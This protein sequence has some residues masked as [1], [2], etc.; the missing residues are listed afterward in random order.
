MHPVYFSPHPLLKGLISTFG[1]LYADF[2]QVNISPNYTFPWSAQ[3]RLNF[4]LQGA[5]I[6]VKKDSASH[7]NRLPLVSL[8]GPQL[9]SSALQFDRNGATA[10]VC[11]HPGG[12]YR[13]TGIPVHELVNQELDAGFVFGPQVWEIGRQLQDAKDTSAVQEIVEGFLLQ[14]LYEKNR[15]LRPFDH[16][17]L[18]LIKSNGNLS[19]STAAAA[20][21]M[22]TRHFERLCNE[23]LGISPKL[24]AR[25]V[26]FSRAHALIETQGGKSLSSIAYECGYYDQ[27]HLIHDCRKFS[28]ATPRMI[29]QELDRSL[30]LLSMLENG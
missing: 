10:C 15:D 24:F 23:Y 21:C 17:I 26:R 30:K 19:I 2:E 11:F 5:P 4:T 18:Q 20:A 16:A 9:S 25:L 12:F 7:F 1:I 6:R 13:L 22:S 3:M 28:G 14:R 8:I 27:M 29:N